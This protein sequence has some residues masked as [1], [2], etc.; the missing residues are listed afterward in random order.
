MFFC[1]VSLCTLMTVQM[2][3]SIPRAEDRNAIRSRRLL[4]DLTGLGKDSPE[5]IMAKPLDS[6]LYHWQVNVISVSK[7]GVYSVYQSG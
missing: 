1:G 3:E 6:C 7:G 5:G 4:H 2:S